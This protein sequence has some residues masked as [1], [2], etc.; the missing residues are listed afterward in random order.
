MTPAVAKISAHGPGFIKNLLQEREIKKKIPEGWLHAQGQWGYWKFR[1]IS[2]YNTHQPC[3][4]LLNLLN[5]P[6]TDADVLC[7]SFNIFPHSL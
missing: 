2:S 4:F 6:H 1:L 3:A 7:Y 5:L